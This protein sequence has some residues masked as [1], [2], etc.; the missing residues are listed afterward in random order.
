MVVTLYISHPVPLIT[1]HL[2]FGIQPLINHVI[3]VYYISAGFMTL[4][5][6]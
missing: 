6:C 1:S 4:L 3:K 2:Y 5:Y